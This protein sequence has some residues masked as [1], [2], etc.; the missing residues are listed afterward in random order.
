MIGTLRP[1]VLVP[2]LVLSTAAV[3]GCSDGPTLVS[4]IVTEVSGD[5][6]SIDSFTL[7]TDDG[8]D[9]V[10]VPDAFGDFAFPLPHLREHVVSLD[11]VRVTY[12][13]TSDGTNVA[14]ALDDG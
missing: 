4:G 14:T 6:V 7:H 5:L 1:L 8:R 13:T 10:L 3:A 9:L 12:R 11:P 2:V